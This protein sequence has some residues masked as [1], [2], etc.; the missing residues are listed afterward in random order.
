MIT[1]EKCR[2][3]TRKHNRKSKLIYHYVC[4]WIGRTKRKYFY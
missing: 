3:I 1:P 4:F 2:A